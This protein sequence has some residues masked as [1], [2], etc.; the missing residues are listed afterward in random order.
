MKTC[1]N[2]FRCQ[3]LCF[4]SG[5]RAK[6]N[7]EPVTVHAVRAILFRSTLYASLLSCSQPPEQLSPL[8]AEQHSSL[9]ESLNGR[10]VDWGYT[11]CPHSTSPCRGQSHQII[12]ASLGG[13]GARFLT[14]WGLWVSEITLERCNDGERAVVRQQH[15]SMLAVSNRQ[16]DTQVI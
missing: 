10:S 3:L 4:D 8:T 12:A 6:L 1:L 13:S 5:Y 7:C 11:W 2:I 9:E 15:C 16:D 14:L